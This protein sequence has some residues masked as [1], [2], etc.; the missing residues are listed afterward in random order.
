MV[1]VPPQ[2]ESTLFYLLHPMADFP[3]LGSGEHII[4]IDQTLRFNKDAVGLPAKGD[5]ITLPEF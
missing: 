1:H 3:C 4:A 2:L 5:E